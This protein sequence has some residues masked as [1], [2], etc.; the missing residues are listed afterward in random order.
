M[1]GQVK[2]LGGWNSVDKNLDVDLYLEYENGAVENKW[3]YN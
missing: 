3:I 2:V 1:E